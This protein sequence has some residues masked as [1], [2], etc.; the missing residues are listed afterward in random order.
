MLYKYSNL[1]TRYSLSAIAGNVK[2]VTY[3]NAN[4]CLIFDYLHLSLDGVIYELLSINNN[5]FKYS[6]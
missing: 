4:D 6:L 3:A 2:I 1:E 5:L